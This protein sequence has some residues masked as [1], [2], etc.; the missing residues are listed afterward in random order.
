[1]KKIK[2]NP[3]D[4]FEYKV[5]NKGIT[6]T[7]YKGKRKKIVIPDIIDGLPIIAIGSDAFEDKKLTHV[8]IPNSVKTIE[9]GAF[10]NNQLTNVIIPDSV[11][12]IEFFAFANNQLTNVAIPNSVKTIGYSAFSDNKLKGAKDPFSIMT[13]KNEITI[14]G[15]NHYER[16]VVIPDKIKGLPVVAISNFAFADNQLTNVVIPNS[17]K[18]IGKCA[19][20]NN[21]LKGAGNPF[22]IMVYK[23][24]ITIIGYNRSTRKLVIPAKINTLPVVTIGDHAFRDNKLTHVVIPDSIKKIGDHAFWHNEL[25]NVIIPDSVKEIGDCAFKD[26]QLTNVVIP[27]SVETIGDFAFR[28]NQLTKIIIPDSVKISRHKAFDDNVK[29][30]RV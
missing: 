7:G 27:N 13:Y 8:V 10:Y 9:G 5:K 1:M 12:T 24:E 21:K 26:N 15:Y 6:I 28:G 11:K 4:D 22:S 14:I 29:I 20:M 25:T 17:V 3:K 30:R 18:I 2:P 19:F 16:E 23:D